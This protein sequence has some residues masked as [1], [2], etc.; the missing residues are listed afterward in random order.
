MSAIIK[1]HQLIGL[2]ERLR[3]RSY[4]ERSRQKIILS[5]TETVFDFFRRVG[6]LQFS[7]RSKPAVRLSFRV[8]QSPRI[9]SFRD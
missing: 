7:P 9:V 6:T 1:Q 8:T 2:H 3:S 5:V 4:Y